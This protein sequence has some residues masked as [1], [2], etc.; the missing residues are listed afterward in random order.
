MSAEVAE[1]TGSR[2]LLQGGSLLALGMMAAN[3]GNYVLNLLLGH[4]LEPSEFA[5][6][7][8]MVTLMLLVTAIA[9]ALQLVAARYASIHQAR[10]SDARADAI[11][12]WLN[13]AALVGGLVL[14]AVLAGLAWFWQDVFNTASAW[15]F[16]IL[17][18]GM[19]AYLVQAVGRGVMQGRLAFGRLALTFLIEMVV[20]VAVASALVAAGLGV[21][22]ATIGLTLSFLA[23]WWSVRVLQPVLARP[24]LSTDELGDLRH[25]V[26]PVL[27][28]LVGQIVINNGDVM[29]VKSVFD[30][31]TAGV[32][33]AIA[34]IGR[35]VFFL[36]WSAVTTLFPAAAQRHE[37]DADTTGL[38][39]GGVAIVA[40]AC[41]AMTILAAVFG[42]TFFT[43]VFGDEYAGV[44]SLLVRYAIATSMF[45][46]ANLIVTHQLS[47]GRSR[48]SL[49]LVGAAI[50]QTLLLLLSND[51]LQTVVTIQIWTMAGLLLAVATST[52]TGLRSTA[53][54]SPPLILETAPS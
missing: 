23:T 25:Y 51:T 10:G 53:D 35:A 12:A 1:R 37:A 48:E 22:G 49:L 46:V 47:A 24:A 29:I 45:A 3:A 18:A 40:G 14:C 44:N 32:Y 9:V 19:P 28:L 27:V 13:R 26:T 33:S 11:A 4:W 39:L 52:A 36:S 7:T 15:P 43:G 31:D 17:A 34:L 5:D 42:D 21:N 30:G 20:R 6:A 16:V 54:R 2:A 38:L 41:T 8:L 50:V